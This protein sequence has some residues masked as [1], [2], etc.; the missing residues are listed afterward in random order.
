MKKRNMRLLVA[1]FIISGNCVSAGQFQV[2]ENR[3][4][5]IFFETRLLPEAEKIAH[6]Y[7]QIRADLESTFGWN[8]G[9][10][11]SIFLV[12]DRKPFENM[13][14]DN[15]IVAFAV[16]GSNRIVID[17]TLIIRHTFRIENTLKHE[18]CH[19][20]LHHHIK[21]H[22][23]PRWL[24]EGVSQWVS[25][26]IGDIILDQKRSYL[27]KAAF[28]GHF[29]PLDS[30]HKGFPAEK[31]ALLLAYEESKGFVSYLISR[32]G[33]DGILSLLGHMKNGEGV[34]TAILKS[35]SMS[36]EGLEREWHHS[37]RGKITWFVYLSYYLYEILF[38]FM[39]L[40]SVYA[41]IRI[42]IKK[43]AYMDED[44]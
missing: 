32:F 43:R 36:L 37:L 5:K 3:D 21:E 42:I 4:M 28:R 9:M 33:K 13:G 20:L 17:Y 7:P 27:S 29:I 41:F 16:P 22:F 19:L 11:P 10:R 30:L 35:F 15:L 24:D 31:D 38:A 12:T 34:N 40:V 44:W 25:D 2:Q 6:I 39:A 14:T 8:L 23:L 18:M 1:A 26:W